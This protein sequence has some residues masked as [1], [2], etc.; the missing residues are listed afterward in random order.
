MSV[1][2]LAALLCGRYCCQYRNYIFDCLFADSGQEGVNMKN[3][4][5]LVGALML[6]FSVALP[7]V[8]AETQA[9]PCATQV[10]TRSQV[11]RELAAAVSQGRVVTE[12]NYPEIFLKPATAR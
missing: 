4:I 5:F 8:A 9:T 11:Q 6:A 12:N 3:R 10:M 1:L 7:A 2:N